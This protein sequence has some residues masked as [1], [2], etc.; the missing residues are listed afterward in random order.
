MFCALCAGASSRRGLVGA[1]VA[2]FTAIG[3]LHLLAFAALTF[4]LNRAR[5]AQLYEGGG[6][7]DRRAAA[8]G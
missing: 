5:A 3:F 8:G 1:F 6:I 4:G 7:P 2:V